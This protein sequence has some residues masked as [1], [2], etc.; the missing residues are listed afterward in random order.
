MHALYKRLKL[1]EMCLT[2]LHINEYASR[3]AA[4]VH[5]FRNPFAA[6]VVVI[7]AAVVG[8]L[9]VC[10]G[11]G[12]EY[13]RCLMLECSHVHVH[14]FGQCERILTSYLARNHLPYSRN[15]CICTSNIYTNARLYMRSES[16]S[17][18]YGKLCRHRFRASDVRCSVWPRAT[19]LHSSGNKTNILY[20]HTH[21][22]I[23]TYTLSLHIT[24]APLPAR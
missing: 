20:T 12:I 7:I 13:A 14:T 10:A 8:V 5:S 11:F 19:I 1:C 9:Y 23:P 18:S 22:M 3:R 24:L 15:I 21:K 6:A 16:V 4:T 2:L 17:Y